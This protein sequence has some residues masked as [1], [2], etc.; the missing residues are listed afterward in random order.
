MLD[1][2]ADEL[3][4]KREKSGVTLQQMANKTRIDIK[5]LEAIDEGNFA[6]LPELY[7]KAF[8]KQYARSVGL[9]EAATIIRYEAARD[10]RLYETV[11]EASEQKHPDMKK[12]DF[13]PPVQTSPPKLKQ[14]VKSY[15]DP[16]V[17]KKQAESDTS[18]KDKMMMFSLIAGILVIIFAVYFLFIRDSKEIIIAERPFDEVLQEN[19]QRYVEGNPD[20]SDAQISTTS[21]SLYLKLISSETSWI[22]IVIDDVKTEEFTLAPNVE[23]TIT[24]GNNFKATVGNSGG[25]NL[26]LNNKPVEFSGRSGSVRH[27]RLDREGLQYLNTPPKLERQ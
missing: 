13:L 25:V 18:G 11:S 2:F 6:F 12:P 9:D 20:K 3:R 23:H 16:S 27:F 5:F 22:F 17:E 15:N 8:I 1:K 24:A 4:D 10:G 19:Q 7:V 14:P 26:I 21:D